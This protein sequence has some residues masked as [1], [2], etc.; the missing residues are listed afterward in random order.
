MGI[1]K[2]MESS[3]KAVF[4]E[5]ERKGKRTPIYV[6]KSEPPMKKVKPMSGKAR[7]VHVNGQM[8]RFR[9]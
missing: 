5:S 9:F 1:S 6:P 3:A 8:V 7:Y 4:G 2:M